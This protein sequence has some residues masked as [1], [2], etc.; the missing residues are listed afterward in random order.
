MTLLDL[1]HRTQDPKPWAEG[2]KIP[3]DD[4]QF[5]A[6]MLNEHLSQTHDAASRRADIID[7]QVAWIH[8]HILGDNPARI[9]DLGCGPGLYASRL[10]E[11]GHRCVGIDFSPASIDYAKRQTTGD[12]PTYMQADI[13]HADYGDGYHKLD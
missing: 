8:H 4:P 13:R 7:Q 9:L 5:S 10:A 11:R 1:V 3:W 2:E 12:N 6:R